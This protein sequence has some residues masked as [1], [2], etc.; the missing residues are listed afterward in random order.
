MKLL[1][2]G[3]WWISHCLTARQAHAWLWRCRGCCVSTFCDKPLQALAV[4]EALQEAGQLE[5]LSDQEIAVLC[6]SHNGEQ[7]HVDIVGRLLERLTFHKTGWHAGRTGRFISPTLISQARSLNSPEKIHNNCSGK[8]A[9]MLV[10]AHL[11][12]HEAANYADWQ[13]PVQRR[14]IRI[15]SQLASCNILSYPHG[16]DGCGAH[17]L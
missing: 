13:H 15:M 14:M 12:G 11:C 5:Q 6:A 2:A 16:I 9:G 3:I 8:H 4:V 1:K 7:Q 17:C 10:L